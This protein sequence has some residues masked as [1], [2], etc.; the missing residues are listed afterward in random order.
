MPESTKSSLPDLHL[1]ITVLAGGVGSRFW[2]VST[3]TRP[4]QLLPLASE[5]PLIEDT[6]QRILALVPRDHI[7]ILT[8]QHLAKPILT[9][10]PELTDNEVL[11]EPRARGTGPVLAWAAAQ[12]Y[13]RDPEAIMASLHSDHVISPDS[14]LREMLVAAAE[15]ARDNQRLLTIGVTPTRPETGYGYIKPGARIDD[16]Y[17]AY[18]VQQFEEKPDRENAT[19]YVQRGYVW[20][21]GIFVWPVKLFLDEI[22]KHATEI[23]PHL[24]L[25]LEG[26]TK[27]FF[28]AVEESS[29]DEAVLERS[30]R[31]GVMPATFHWDDVGAWDAVGRTRAKDADGNV[32]VGNVRFVDTNN[33]IGWCEDGKLVVFGGDDLVVVKAGDITFVAD[34]DRTPDMKQLLEQI[35]SWLKQN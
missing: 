21:S 24:H 27:G 19:Q 4:K 9:A 13:N 34:R 10:V 17:D 20:N 29:V 16:K 28:D 5:Q 14:A 32:S 22:R 3:P 33:S 7:R 6:V 31:V 25:A 18:E 23:A 15:C 12:I 35:D 26:D 8:G 2:P 30:D 11:V 1:W